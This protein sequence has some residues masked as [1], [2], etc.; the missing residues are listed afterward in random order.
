ML[1]SLA[2]QTPEVPA[3]VPVALLDGNLEEIFAKVSRAGYDGVEIISTDPASLD[4][5]LLKKILAQ[6]HLQVSAIASG[7]MAFAAKLTLLN[8]DLNAAALA[9][10]RLDEMIDLASDLAAPVVTVGSFRGR[11][12]GDKVSSLQ[13]LADVL[14]KAGERA[15]KRGVRIA[16]EPLNRYEADLLNT[17]AQTL[18]FLQK[19]D[20]P[21]IG[22]LLDTYHIN[23]EESSWTEPYRQVMNAQK[24][25]YVHLGD[26]NRQPPG[27]GLIDFP[28]ILHTL[29]EGG[30]NGWL[31]AELLPLPDPET[32]VRDVVTT[33][34]KWM[35]EIS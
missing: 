24:L 6:N 14:R 12:M 16:L 4:R 25:F 1:L 33:M 5:D 7:G 32:A 22:I 30:Y 31:S 18:D 23:I 34:R 26:N 19:V 9:R 27:K 28:A 3:R 13:V 8:P 15:L 21:A 20:H 17:A 29:Q 11:E 35:G 2:I 10:Q